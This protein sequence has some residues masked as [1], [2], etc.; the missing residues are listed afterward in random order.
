VVSFVLLDQPS[1]VPP[2]T[3]CRVEDKVEGAYEFADGEFVADAGMQA[4]KE[5]V[6][7]M[8]LLAD[9]GEGRPSFYVN[10]SDDSY[11][12]LR[13][14][15]NYRS[16]LRRVNLRYIRAK[17]SER[18]SGTTPLVLG[19][20]SGTL[21]QPSLISPEGRPTLTV[22]CGYATESDVGGVPD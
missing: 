21:A 17:L 9:S 19:G 14:F 8:R 5:R 11:W 1:A 2:G 20:H 15:E 12:E 22:T 3:L 6:G 10:P 13:E 4:I 16:E 7:V 18:R